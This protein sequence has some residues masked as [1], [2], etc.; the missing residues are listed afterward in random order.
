[1]FEGLISFNA[2][3]VTVSVLAHR[4][5]GVGT[6]G[7][8]I[9]PHVTVQGALLVKN[10]QR[11]EERCSQTNLKS[12]TPLPQIIMPYSGKNESRGHRRR[13]RYSSTWLN[14]AL[15]WFKPEPA[16]SRP[17]LAQILCKSWEKQLARLGDVLC[18]TVNISKLFI[19]NALER[20]RQH[21][22]GYLQLL[23]CKALFF[24]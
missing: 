8:E 22:C 3:H 9:V 20:L 16:Q 17:T 18:D 19:K 13:L 14:Y 11:E 1:M 24:F 12:V 15:D 7:G 10:S 4:Y 2:I 5:D 6:L 21:G 23:I